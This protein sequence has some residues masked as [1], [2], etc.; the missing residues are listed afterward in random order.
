MSKRGR[1]RSMGGR[2]SAGRG[3]GGGGMMQQIQKMQEDMQ[4]II[5]EGESG[6]GLVKASC[7]A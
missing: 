3:M 2:S 6:A 1:G 5:V 7:T 4:N